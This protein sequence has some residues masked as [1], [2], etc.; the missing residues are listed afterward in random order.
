[1]SFRDPK[2]FQLIFSGGLRIAASVLSTQASFLYQRLNSAERF[3]GTTPAALIAKEA[4]F[5]GGVSL[6]GLV[7]VLL[8]LTCFQR[9]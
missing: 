3:S 4:W 8:F 6:G 9:K 5:F 7:S 2:I 1:M